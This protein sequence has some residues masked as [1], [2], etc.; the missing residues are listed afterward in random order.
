MTLWWKGEIFLIRRPMRHS[1]STCKKRRN[2]ATSK[3]PTQRTPKSC[4]KPYPRLFSNLFPI[5]HFPQRKPNNGINTSSV[6]L[7]VEVLCYN[8]EVF[9][10]LLSNSNFSL[11][12]SSRY[13]ASGSLNFV[14]IFVIRRQYLFRCI[15]KI[16][17]TQFLHIS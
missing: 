2:N 13:D 10:I 15:L 9:L 4:L 12:S 5:P 14:I 1:I 17:R 8:S 3:V 7:N 6:S 16:L 11:I